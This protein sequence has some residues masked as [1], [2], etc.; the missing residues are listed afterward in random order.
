MSDQRSERLA[1]LREFA[2][3]WNRHDIEALMSFMTPNCVFETASGSE[4]WGTRVEGHAEVQ[5]R[6]EAVWEA[7]PDVQFLA[8]D[9]LVDGDRGLSEWTLTGSRNDGT[10]IEVKGCDVIRFDGSKI[11]A[12]SAKAFINSA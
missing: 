7:I 6:F 4:K 10:R 11:A 5:A 12:N 2:A 8:D 1:V 3:A 9:H